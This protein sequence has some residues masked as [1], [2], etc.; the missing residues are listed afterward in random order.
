[1]AE[2]TSIQP[3]HLWSRI[4]KA[5]LILALTLVVLAILDPAQLWPTLTFAAGA[6]W[7]TAPFI[8][9]AVLAVAWLKV[10]GAE[11][12]LARAFEGSQARMVLI[13]ALIGGLAP[14]CSCEVIPHEVC[15][16]AI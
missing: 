4:D 8:A 11:R 1:M 6:L 10:T 12:L 7:H 14:F 3:G 15:T 13:A 9:F 2:T 5:W 16:S